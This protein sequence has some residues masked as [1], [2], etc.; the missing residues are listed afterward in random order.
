[1]R[2]V[3]PTALLVRGHCSYDSIC[4]Y[5]VEKFGVP[6]E[7]PGGWWNANNFWEP[8]P[9]A[10]HSWQCG[11]AEFMGRNGR[12]ARS[13]AARSF[14]ASRMGNISTGESACRRVATV[15]TDKHF[16]VPAVVLI[17]GLLLLRIIH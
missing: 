4:L 16:W 10:V 3:S 7:K 1:M 6:C 11:D 12:G 5:S 15:V 8:Q 9:N 13:A 2:E 14:P 17:G